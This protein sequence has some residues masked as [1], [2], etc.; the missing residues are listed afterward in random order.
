[1]KESSFW[2]RLACVAMVVVLLFGGAV[3]PQFHSAHI[4]WS[5]ETSKRASSFSVTALPPTEKRFALIIGVS[6]YKDPAVPQLIAPANDADQLADALVSTGT[7]LKEHVVILSTDMPE[8]FQPEAGIILQTLDKLAREA[9]RDGLLL[10]A[11]SGH[12][13]EV[14]GK[15]YLLGCDARMIPTLELFQRTCVAWSDIS[16]TINDANVGQ[17]IMLLDACRS[18][19]PKSRGLRAANQP[20]EIYERDVFVRRIGTNQRAVLKMLA[21]QNGEPAYEDGTTKLGLFMSAVV[22]GLKGKAADSDGVITIA[23]LR[24]FI[25]EEVPARAQSI[26]KRQQ[27]VAEIEGYDQERVVIGKA[28]LT[29]TGES[30]RQDVRAKNRTDSPMSELKD[31][32]NVRKTKSVEELK[33]FIQLHPNGTLAQ[34]AASRILDLEEEGFTKQTASP[35]EQA[36]S[37]DVL[38]VRKGDQL[39]GQGK[40]DKAADEYRQAIKL[41]SGRAV[42]Y[43]KLGIALYLQGKLREAVTE[44]KR[45]TELEKFSSSFIFNFGLAL[46][47]QQKYADAETK[48]RQA[49]KLNPNDAS[50]HTGLGLS[51]AH[52]LQGS[53]EAEVEFREAIKLNP[54]NASYHGNLASVLMNLKRFREA[55]SEYRRALDL[56]PAN[57]GYKEGIMQARRQYQ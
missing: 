43:G 37:A 2:G 50:F 12:G 54:S 38:Y 1:M 39:L 8:Q 31:W 9:D 53:R 14:E 52:Q 17:I 26:G 6:D 22:D 4:A 23:R 34:E 46:Y 19:P 30:E 45:A 40:P 28:P 24:R 7:F 16:K 15:A 47:K 3:A 29:P 27:P 41:N 18:E 10:V 32:I 11:Y 25:D 49:V 51:L 56:D 42:Y 5:Q 33:K 57:L 13:Y 36:P 44:Y 20:T 21:T 48:F 55:E 35:T